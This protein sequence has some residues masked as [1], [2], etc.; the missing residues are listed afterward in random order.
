MNDRVARLRIGPYLFL[1]QMPRGRVADR[2]LA[3]H[4]EHDTSHAVHRLPV[5]PSDHADVIEALEP[6]SRLDHPHILPIEQ[7]SVGSVGGGNAWIVAPFTG[8]HDGLLTLGDLL[9]AKGGRTAVP[10]AERTLLQLLG[11]SRYS[12]VLGFHHGPVSMDEV[13]VDRG[14]SLA[15]ELYGVARSLRQ[16]GGAPAEVVRDEVRSIAEIGYQMMTGLP[17]DEPRIPVTR[18]VRRLDRR[19]DEWYRAGLDP[20]G[21]FA[22]ADAALSALPAAH[23]EFVSEVVL[24]P[25]Q[26]VIRGLGRAL[27]AR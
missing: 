10:E 14:G 24:S 26:T 25:V 15:V 1:R 19:W 18:L 4:E 17:A 11:A 5:P 21:G 12:H 8:T 20:S 9:A 23:P 3:V 27:R 7:V 16:R 13:L 22:S 6:L 2:W